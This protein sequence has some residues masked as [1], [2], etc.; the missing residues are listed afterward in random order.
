MTSKHYCSRSHA[1]SSHADNFFASFTPFL[2]FLHAEPPPPPHRSPEQN[3][4]MK[5][6]FAVPS[7]SSSFAVLCL[8][9]LHHTTRWSSPPESSPEPNVELGNKPE[10]PCVWDFGFWNWSLRVLGG[11]TLADLQQA[12]EDYLPVLL[13]LV[14]D[15]SHLQYKVQFI[16]VNQEDD[17]EE[18]GMSNAWFEVLSVLHLMGMLSL[19]QANL[20]LLPRTS[21]D[22]YQPKVSEG[23]LALALTKSKFQISEHWLI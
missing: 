6:E 20:L 1:D 23:L 15:G 19:S 10:P 5:K 21:A 7:A 11:S 2:C 22:G 3:E 17:A 9:N 13:G 4:E 18:T 12:L 14:K 8:P 16:W